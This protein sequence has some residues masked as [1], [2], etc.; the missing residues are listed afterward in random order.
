MP[1]FLFLALGVIFLVVALRPFD[2]AETFDLP[3]EFWEIERWAEC[4]SS[5]VIMM[6][7]PLFAVSENRA[8]YFWSIRCVEDFA[9]ALN[10]PVLRFIN[11]IEVKSGGSELLFYDAMAS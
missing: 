11:G 3:S 5:S 10:E 2:E 1:S 4:L 7:S 8:A 6:H 9:K